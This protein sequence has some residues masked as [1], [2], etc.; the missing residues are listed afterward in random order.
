MKVRTIAALATATALVS[1]GLAIGTLGGAAATNAA[2]PHGWPQSARPSAPDITTGQTLKIVAHYER[3]RAIDVGR[4]GDS[5]GDYNVF[6]ETLRDQSGAV[7]GSDSAR[8]M[9]IVMSY[10]CDATFAFRG[11][12]TIEVSGSFIAPAPLTLAVTGGTGAYQNVRGQ[13]RITGGSGNNTDF[14]FSLIP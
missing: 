4:T 9:N 5:P 11:K 6:E 7:I 8:C 12:G 2:M 10:R 13:A 1:G 14:T 3:F